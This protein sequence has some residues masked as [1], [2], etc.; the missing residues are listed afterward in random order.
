MGKFPQI[1]NVVRLAA[2]HATK[3]EPLILALFPDAD[4]HGEVQRYLKAPDNPAVFVAERTDGSL[5]GFIEVGT[6]PYAEGCETS[7][8][9]FIEAWYVAEEVR[10]QGVGRGFFEAA[11]NWAREQGLSEIASDTLID[12]EV[13][14]AAH[15][16]LGYEEVERIVCFRRRL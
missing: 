11:E 2:P 13:S 4:A 9:A 14:I 8:V 16:A 12:N 7:P 3:L 1:S 10:R 15:K 5:V 6:R